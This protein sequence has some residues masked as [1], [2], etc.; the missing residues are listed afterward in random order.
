MSILLWITIEMEYKI[1]CL[2]F[3]LFFTNGRQK[4]IAKGLNALFRN[5]KF[6]FWYS[7]VLFLELMNIHD[8]G[9]FLGRSSG[10]IKFKLLLQLKKTLT[11]TMVEMKFDHGL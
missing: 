10:T 5:K 6:F 3:I 9:T 8:V 1:K 4:L 11:K 7:V 2:K